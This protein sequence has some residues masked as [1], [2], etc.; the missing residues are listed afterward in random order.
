MIH[1]FLMNQVKTTTLIIYL[2]ELLAQTPHHVTWFLAHHINSILLTDMC[3]NMKKL[4]T[5]RVDG[6]AIRFTLPDGKHA[7]SFC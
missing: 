5:Y 4:M 7:P 6:T 2:E 3:Y 1:P